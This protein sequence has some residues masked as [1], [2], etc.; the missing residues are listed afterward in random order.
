MTVIVFDGKVLAADRQ[1][2]DGA[3]KRPGTKIFRLPS[4]D[5]IGMA[6]SVRRAMALLDWAYKG[7]QIDSYPELKDKD[8]WTEMLRIKPDGTILDY[9][10]AWPMLMEQD[11]YV[12][13]SG[14]PYAQTALYLGNDAV[15]S[16]EITNALT[17]TCGLGVSSLRLHDV[18]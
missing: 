5:L 13:G 4:G 17:H 10:D 8:D 7:F 9:E 14:A 18:D 3:Y 1:I 15:R 6:G 16:V 11:T 2:S 12:I